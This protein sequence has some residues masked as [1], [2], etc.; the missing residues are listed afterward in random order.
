MPVQRTL[1][2]LGAFLSLQ[3]AIDEKFSALEEKD[4]ELQ[5]LHRAVRERDHDL[6]RLR[7]VL[8]ANETTMQVSAKSNLLSF[9]SPIIAFYA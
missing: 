7:S 2:N 8:S 4:K 5:Q 1:R 6:E 9:P 3:R